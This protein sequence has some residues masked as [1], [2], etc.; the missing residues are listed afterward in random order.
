MALMRIVALAASP[1][2]VCA[3]YRVA[4]FRPHFERAGHGFILRTFPRIWWSRWFLGRELAQ[5][6]VVIIQRRLLSTWQLRLLRSHV[7]RLVFDF[8]DAVFLRDSYDPRGMFSRRRL[9]DFAAMVAAADAVVAGNDYLRQQA[10][11]WATSNRLHVIPT[12]VEP[13]KYPVAAHRPRPDATRLVWIGS[14]S[15][16]QGLVRIRP[17]L[18]QLGERFP[19]LRLKLICDQSLE[20][21]SLPVEFCVWSEQTEA[22]EL[23]AADIGISWLPNDRW[24]LG[25]CGLKVLQYMAAG[26]PVIAN[27]VGVQAGFVEHGVSGFWADTPAEWID[28]VGRLMHDVELRQRQGLAGRRRVERHFPVEGG[29]A[30]WLEVLERLVQA[31]PIAA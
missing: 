11:H 14:A 7:R 12:C 13:L 18:N 28:A 30:L 4:A 1:D 19:G 26:L 31:Q 21:Q 22:Q 27:P 16:L 3:R 23:A 17:L 5:A 8:D 25:K 9:H 6:D 24:S 2:H 15:T 10:L 29:A 20:L